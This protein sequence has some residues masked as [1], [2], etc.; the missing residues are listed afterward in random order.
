M[1]L[2]NWEFYE[3]GAALVGATVKVRD[4]VLT[5]PNTGTVLDTTT[6]SV[7]GAW[8][9]TGLTDT[10]KDVEVI[11]GN[12]GQFHR[13]YKGSTRHVLGTITFTEVFTL[14]DNSVSTI[15]IVN[16]AVTTGKINDLAITTGKLG[17]LAVSTGKLIDG[18]LS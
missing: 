12:V 5:H 16:L 18:C 13:W 14:P 6:T 4:A 2:R 8:A 7:D 11:W 17:D 10:A 1:D 9:F 3:S 15:K